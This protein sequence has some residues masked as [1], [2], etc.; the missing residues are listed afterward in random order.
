MSNDGWIKHDGKGMPVDGDVL[1]LCRFRDGEDEVSFG[2]KPSK[3]SYWHHS[4]KGLSNWVHE[5]PSSADIIAYRIV[6]EQKS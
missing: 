4:C 2:W 5:L 6:E 3:A 1:V